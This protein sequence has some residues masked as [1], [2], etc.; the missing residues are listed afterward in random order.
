[1]K[2]TPLHPRFGVEV[3]QVDLS[4][5][6][7]ADGY[8]EIRDLFDRHLLLLFRRQALDAAQHLALGR[9]FGPI[10]DRSGS[11]DP[12]ETISVV[13]NIDGDEVVGDEEDLRVLRNV[14][15]Q[16]WHT[17]STF[18]PVPAL[19]NILRAEVLPSTGGETEFVS[20]RAAWHDMPDGLQARIRE[21]VIRHRFTHSVARASARLAR[22]ERY[23]KW[24]DQHWRALWPNPLTGEEALYIASHACG[25]EGMDDAEA[26]LLIDELVEFCTREEYVYSH[27][28]Q[29]GDV[30]IWDER[31]TLHRGRPWP[32]EEARSLCSIC[33]SAGARDGL[34]AVRP[35]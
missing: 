34:D 20:T 7:A 35:G 18:L 22:L 14:A 13:S 11:P 32:Y 23:T 12:I 17:D 3:E 16:Q 28:W 6:T 33:I 25:V 19:A 30:L 29:V 5:V 4:Q 27:R 9:L 24:P 26:Q 31:A 15:N 10:E 21:R 1:M 2:T 8:D